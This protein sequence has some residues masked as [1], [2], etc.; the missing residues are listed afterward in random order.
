MVSLDGISAPVYEKVRKGS[1]FEKVVKNISNFS[2]LKRKLGVSWPELQLNFVM[3]KANIHEGLGLVEVAKKL[4]ATSVEYHHAVPTNGIDLGDEKLE[5]HPDLF[6]AYRDR[7]LESCKQNEIKVYMP[8]ALPSGGTMVEQ[9]KEPDLT[10]FDTV[11]NQYEPEFPEVTVSK[12]PP[13]HETHGIS[14]IYPKLFCELPFEEIY[15]I[16]QSIVRPCPFQPLVKVNLKDHP[17]LMSAYFSEPFA[18]LRKAMFTEK[19]HP[20]CAQCPLK[21]GQLTVEA[22][23]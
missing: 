23:F 19:G 7:I 17:N 11:Y 6:N 18:E 8:D 16:D 1:K 15:V 3:M 9:T 10:H 13:R 22:S 5:N 21:D 4:G 2:M 20:G 12:H 14:E